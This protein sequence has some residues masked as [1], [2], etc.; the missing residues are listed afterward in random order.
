MGEAEIGGY[1]PSIAVYFGSLDSTP[2]KDEG[3]AWLL[4]PPLDLS[5]VPTE[6]MVVFSFNHY[7]DAEEGRDFAS[8]HVS[9]DNGNSFTIRKH[10]SSAFGIC[11]PTRNWNSRILRLR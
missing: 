7:L 6:D 9:V 3:D 5:N 10:G 4:G 11:P 1:S 8:V 2:N